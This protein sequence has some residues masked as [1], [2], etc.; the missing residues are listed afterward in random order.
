MAL[1]DYLEPKVVLAVAVTAAVLSPPVR[2]ALGRGTVQGLA[3]LL[4]LGET[5]SKTARGVV[6]QARQ[7]NAAEESAGADSSSRAE[8][9]GEPA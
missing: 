6:E 4:K 7:A 8:P 1:D 3:A 9:V 5:V 2:K